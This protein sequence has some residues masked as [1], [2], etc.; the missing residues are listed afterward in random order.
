MSYIAAPILIVFTICFAVYVFIRSDDNGS[1]AVT[2]LQL[3]LAQMALLNVSRASLKQQLVSVQ[4]WRPHV[5]MLY[6]VLS[7]D[8]ELDI[9]CVG[10]R[11][12]DAGVGRNDLAGML[13]LASQLKMAKG[14]LLTMGVVVCEEE[15]E[16]EGDNRGKGGGSIPRSLTQPGSILLPRTTSLIPKER[17]EGSYQRANEEEFD[18]EDRMVRAGVTG[19]AKCI[20]ARS[21]ARGRSFG[22]QVR[23]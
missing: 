2:G 10:D 18:M 11:G 23:A 8:D 12:G 3:Q 15:D 1:S 22:L 17:L 16:G 6:K 9:D 14:L 5:M 19:F 20:V 13:T 4:N 7:K 21:W